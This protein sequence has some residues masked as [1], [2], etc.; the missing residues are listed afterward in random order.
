MTVGVWDPPLARP[1]LTVGLDTTA[2]IIFA[3]ATTKATSI[4]LGAAGNRAILAVL[5]FN[6]DAPSSISVSSSPAPSGGTA[7][8]AI[9]NAD[10]GTAFATMRQVMWGASGFAAGSV[11]V[12]A[13]WTGSASGWLSLVSFNGA[14]QSGPFINGTTFT[15][16][17][18]GANTTQSMAITASSGDMAVGYSTIVG[19]TNFYVNAG[20]VPAFEGTNV[21]NQT[22]GVAAAQLIL[23]GYCFSPAGSTTYEIEISLTASNFLMVGCDVAAAPPETWTGESPKGGLAA[24]KYDGRRAFAGVNRAS[25]AASHDARQLALLTES[26]IEG[27]PTKPA[28]IQYGS[29]G[30]YREYLWPVYAGTRTFSIAVKHPGTAPYPTLTLM[31]EPQMG[32]T[33]QQLTATSHGDWQTLTLTVTVAKTGVLRVRTQVYAPTFGGPGVNPD[34]LRCWAA[35]DNIALT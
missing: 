27:Y 20:F 5:N 18:S 12:T 17:T 30:Q 3:A 10:T 25:L 31:D 33:R 9:A 35:W 16:T 14:L 7:W 24:Y 8:A 34:W 11:T 28:A 23:T 15:G 22:S 13:S 29:A 4:T 6:T 1:G 32:V 21:F 19:S 2:S 26:L